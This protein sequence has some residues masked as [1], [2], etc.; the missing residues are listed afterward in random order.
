MKKGGGEF[1]SDPVVRIPCS[2]CREPKFDPC[3]GLRSPKLC[4]VGQK[5][6]GRKIVWDRLISRR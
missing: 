5:N 1:S 6:S 2:H 3:Q 4:G